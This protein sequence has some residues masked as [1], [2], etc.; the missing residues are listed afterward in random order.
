MGSVQVAEAK[1]NFS[2]IL[3]DVRAGNEY[4]ITSGQRREPVGVLVP[5]E[6]WKKRQPRIAGTLADRGELV[7]ADDWE[8][9]DEE[10]CGYEPARR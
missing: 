3:K 8:M 5:Y 2:A 9:T 4:I 1:A 6:A 7:F 10:L